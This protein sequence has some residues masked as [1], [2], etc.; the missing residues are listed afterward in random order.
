MLILGRRVGESLLVELPDD[1]LVITVLSMGTDC[2][3]VR[4]H[5]EEADISQRCF[6][7]ECEP[8]EIEIA[9]IRITVVVAEVRS[10]HVR[11][12][13]DA[14]KGVSISRTEVPTAA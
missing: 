10:L 8:F 7:L 2:A 6:L 9:G 5:L 14:P 11:L 13:I 3:R 12:G 1:T 4:I